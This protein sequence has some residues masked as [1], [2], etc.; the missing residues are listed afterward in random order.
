[1][2]VSDV[3]DMLNC[4]AAV[5]VLMHHKN[6][7]HKDIKAMNVMYA[8]DRRWVVSGCLPVCVCV[9]PHVCTRAFVCLCAV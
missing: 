8:G 6:I 1:M 4:V 3:F 2:P 9:G 5:L 7:V